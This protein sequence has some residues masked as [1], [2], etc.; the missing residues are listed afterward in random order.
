MMTYDDGARFIGPKFSLDVQMCAGLQIRGQ[1]YKEEGKEGDYKAQRDNEGIS[2]SLA[3]L[4]YLFSMS[5]VFTQS[6][7]RRCKSQMH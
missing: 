4:F 7:T 5:V 1:L 6:L 2:G 3:L